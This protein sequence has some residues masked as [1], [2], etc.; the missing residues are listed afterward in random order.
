MPGFM[1]PFTGYNPVQQGGYFPP[2]QNIGMP[3]QPF[4]QYN[5]TK[6]IPQTTTSS[7]TSTTHTTGTSGGTKFSLDAPIYTP[8]GKGPISTVSTST[9]SSKEQSVPPS[10][11][12][13]TTTHII[14]KEEKEITMERKTIVPILI[15]ETSPEVELETPAPINE[16]TEVPETIEEKKLIQMH[17]QTPVEEFVETKKE[18]QLQ[19]NVNKP[20]AE[21]QQIQTPTKKSALNNLFNKTGPTIIKS[22]PTSA[23]PASAKVVAKKKPN[24][25]H[26]SQLQKKMNNTKT[27]Q[28]GS[29]RKGSNV[30]KPKEQYSTT[31]DTYIEEEEVVRKEEAIV[32]EEV[33]VQEPE[34]E[35]F[36]I[37]RHYFKVSDRKKEEIN[38]K[39][40]VDFLMAFKDVFISSLI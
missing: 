13:S 24:E 32:I 2:S 5:Q 10:I 9:I 8:K 20:A 6:S 14:D 1:M 38:K 17:I 25:D 22:I 16:K 31:K 18:P 29:D 11:T 23:Q 26:F 33:K 28:S 36:E 35:K 4:N 30:T 27:T 21:L 12:I 7:T 15:K 34:P 19:V 37:I 40:N 3:Q 39:S